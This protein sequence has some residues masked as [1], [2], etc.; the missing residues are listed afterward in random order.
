MGIGGIKLFSVNH[1]C[2]KCGLCAALCPSKIIEMTDGGVPRV[3]AARE[4]SCIRCGQCVAFCPKSC[5][6]LDFQPVEERIAVDAN[7][8]PSLRSAETLLRS[9]RSIRSYR[10]ESLP[11][12]LMQ[13]L[14]ETARYAPSASN[15]QPVR[16]IITNTRK[17]TLKLGSLVAD[18]FREVVKAAEQ[19]AEGVKGRVNVLKHVVSEWDQGRDMIFRGAPQLVVAVVP[20]SHTFPEDGAIALTYL[21]L[22]AHAHEVGCCWAGF[23]TMAARNSAALQAELGVRDDELIVGGQMIGYSRLPISKMLPPRKK[24]DI[25]WL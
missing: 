5:C 13:R 17:E 11:K 23:F 19:S 16:W 10:E 24:V 20:K 7:L 6:F 12:E 25:S 2:I 3:E 1:N 18:Y 9:R 15:S 22:A 21:E 8:M 4:K 14:L